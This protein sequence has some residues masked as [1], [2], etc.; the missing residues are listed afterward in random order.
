VA[1]QVTHYKVFVASP[2]GLEPE[3]KV[4][5]NAIQEHNQAD[6]LARDVCFESIGWEITLG[7]MGRPQ[8]RINAD[9]EECDYFVLVLWNR[10]GSSTGIEG[11]TSGTHEEFL[12]AQSLLSDVSRPM[13]DIVILFKGVDADRLADAGPQLS[14]VMDFRRSI[15]EE[16]KFLYHSFDSLESLSIKIK[17]HLA[18]WTRMHESDFNSAAAPIARDAEMPSDLPQPFEGKLD[19]ENQTDF[20]RR[21]AF[22]K[23]NVRSMSAFDAYGKFLME[24]GR[25]TDAEN[26]YREM[27]DIAREASDRRGTAMAMARLG[28]A[29]RSQGRLASAQEALEASLRIHRA[30]DDKYGES[31]V[32]TYLGDM[33]AS[34]GHFGDALVSY[35]NAIERNPNP[36]RKVLAALNWKIAKARAGTGDFARAEASA[37][38]ADAM[39]A[40]EQ[41]RDLR[42]SIKQW[43]KAHRAS[44]TESN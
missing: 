35:E 21:L 33:A 32:L 11:M 28:G 30:D 7:G 38:I 31:I 4:F 16:K 15:E 22:D 29:Y 36:P 41:M 6:A 26:V 42:K 24:Q 12:F 13:R 27:H 37:K 25:F 3:R 14:K 44:V 19:G 18:N 20:E 23:T 8:A 43:R 1:R 9:L 10:W 2:G 5:H 40:E 34:A 39:A 17:E